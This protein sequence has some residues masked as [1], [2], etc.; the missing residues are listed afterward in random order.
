[1]RKTHRFLFVLFIASGLFID[2]SGQGPYRRVW[3][4]RYGGDDADGT[5]CFIQ[6]ADHGFV[7][8]GYSTSGAT[9][10]KTQP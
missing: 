4:Y 5:T 10:D 6:S 7:I 2:A 3:D 9:G 8:A 1:M